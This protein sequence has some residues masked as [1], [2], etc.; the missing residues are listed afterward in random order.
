MSVVWEVPVTRRPR[1]A[2]PPP[3]P[4]GDG[5][6]IKPPRDRDPPSSG[7]QLTLEQHYAA[8]RE[9]WMLCGAAHRIWLLTTIRP[10][11]PEGPALGP[12]RR[13]RARLQRIFNRDFTGQFDPYEDIEC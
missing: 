5:A 9:L 6:H 2:I 10:F 1:P 8:A 11:R 7:H 12:V 3:P 4:S 13:V